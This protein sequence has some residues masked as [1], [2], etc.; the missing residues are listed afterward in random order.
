MTR[1]PKGLLSAALLAATSSHPPIPYNQRIET[2][3]APVKVANPNKKKQRKA[4]A[5]ARQTTR[6]KRK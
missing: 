3:K 1:F 6:S 4:Q 2:P 5:K